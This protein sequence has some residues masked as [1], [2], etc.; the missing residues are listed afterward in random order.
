VN[1]ADLPAFDDE[2]IRAMA[3]WPDVPRCYGWLELDRRGRW[4]LRGEIIAH[5]R[6]TAFLGHHYR[7]DAAG[8]WYVQNGP[9]Q[10]FVSLEYT[11]WILR[12]AAGRLVTHTGVDARV[13]RAAC[14]DDEGNVVLDTPLGAGLLDDRDLAAFDALIDYGSDTPSALEWPGG[15]RLPFETV[16]RAAVP[17]RFGFVAVPAA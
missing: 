13:P 1:D 2:V 11:P 12:Y 3:R 10:V 9:Q 16:A 4:R 14:L 7:A 15:P 6:A 5:A 17:A 8:R